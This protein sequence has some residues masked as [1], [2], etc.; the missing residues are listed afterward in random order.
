[1][2]ILV[3]GSANVDTTLR[4]GRFPHPG[5]TLVAASSG[6]DIGGKGLNQAIAC[7]RAGAEVTFLTEVGDDEEG[8]MIIRALAKERLSPVILRKKDAKTGHAYIFVNDDGENEIVIT[9]GA[10][11]RFTVKDIDEHAELIA[12]HDIII[13]Q[14]E[15]ALAVNE[16][17]LQLAGRHGKTVIVDPAP[18]VKM[19]DQYFK[20]IDYYVPNETELALAV[21]TPVDLKARCRILL[22]KGV[23]NVIVTLGDEGS[24]FLNAFA[25][26]YVPAVKVTAV[27]TVAAGDTYVGYLAAALGA[28]RSLPEAMRLATFAAAITVTRK[29]AVAAIPFLSELH[30]IKDA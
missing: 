27:D 10:N 15:L 1:M 11:G 30:D 7:A 9:K 22:A 21:P 29:G 4:I 16:H 12:S 8:A 14:N 25:T 28:G 23:K 18:F 5:E 6:I 17:V 20:Y 13:L 26:G 3:I 2:K 19:P 24:F